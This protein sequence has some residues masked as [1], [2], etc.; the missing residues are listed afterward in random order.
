[1]P[2]KD[3]FEI[4]A[5][6]VLH[7]QRVEGQPEQLGNI[8]ICRVGGERGTLFVLVDAQGPRRGDIESLLVDTITQSYKRATVS[9]SGALGAAIREANAV[10]LAE[11]R[12]SL[13]NQQTSA[14][15]YC[16][17]A[18]PGQD[19]FLAYCGPGVALMLEEGK[20][21]HLPSGSER[22]PIEPGATAERD[23]TSSTSL[24]VLP[25]IDPRMYNTSFTPG[26]MLVLGSDSMLDVDLD[27]EELLNAIGDS[28]VD[29]I[30]DDRDVT[31]LVVSYPLAVTAATREATAAAA[32]AAA[33]AGGA[34]GLAAA[35]AVIGGRIAGA[36]RRGAGINTGATAQADAAPAAQ[37]AGAVSAAQAASAVPDWLDDAT[38]QTGQS[39]QSKRS[40]GGRPRFRVPLAW[41]AVLVGVVVLIIAAVT[42]Q[43]RM[44]QQAL[45]KKFAVAGCPGRRPAYIGPGQR[46]PYAGGDISAGGRIADQSGACP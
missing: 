21:D 6:R 40:A 23:V 27:D 43:G 16:A 19:L 37:A 41:I 25:N 45:N 44:E 8:G 22:I 4:S 3:P 34:G 11:N 42:I 9:M 28:G 12:T 5:L 32:V 17:V 29:G 2:A 20:L 1:M 14:G 15:V 10:L 35:G 13:R 30:P 39:K 24:G 46:R 18:R 7:G 26:Q 36:F 31:A 38:A 33:P